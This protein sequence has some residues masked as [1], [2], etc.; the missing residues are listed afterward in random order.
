MIQWGTALTFLH[1]L[2]GVV[3]LDKFHRVGDFLAL[4]YIVIQAQV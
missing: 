2:E 1:S 3:R 4:Q